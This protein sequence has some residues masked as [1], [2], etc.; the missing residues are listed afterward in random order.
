MDIDIKKEDDIK[1]EPKGNF[2]N[3]PYYLPPF[4]SFGNP[5]ANLLVAGSADLCVLTRYK[6]FISDNEKDEKTNP[7]NEDSKKDGGA[8]P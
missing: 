3:Y 5:S 8:N 1:S 6:L 4:Y 2:L 7:T